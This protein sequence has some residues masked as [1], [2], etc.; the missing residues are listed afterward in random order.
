[1]NFENKTKELKEEYIKNNNLLRQLSERNLKI[2]WQL[3][4][5]EEINTIDENTKDNS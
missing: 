4:L 1:M 2:V 3:E 5:I